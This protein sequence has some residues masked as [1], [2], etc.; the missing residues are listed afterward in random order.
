MN[1]KGFDVVNVRVLLKL[2]S[3]S[4]ELHT[5]PNQL[6]SSIGTTEFTHYLDNRWPI[7]IQ[8][9]FDIFLMGQL[10]LVGRQWILI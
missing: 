6:N 4:N 1:S 7:C 8:C 2:P 9:C 5:L 10:D 3:L